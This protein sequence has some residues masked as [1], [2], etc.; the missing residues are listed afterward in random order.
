[1]AKIVAE[2]MH[3]KQTGIYIY[4]YIKGVFMLCFFPPFIMGELNSQDKN[5]LQ[6]RGMNAPRQGN[7]SEIVAALIILMGTRATS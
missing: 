4:I 3:L 6:L 5:N 2:L 7:N 1:M